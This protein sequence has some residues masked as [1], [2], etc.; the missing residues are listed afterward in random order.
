MHKGNDEY[1]EVSVSTKMLPRGNDH[2]YSTVQVLYAIRQG[3]K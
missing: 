3:R 1:T 2:L